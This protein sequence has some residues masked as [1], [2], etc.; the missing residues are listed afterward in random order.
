MRS[1]CRFFLTI[2]IC[3]QAT[4]ARA[5]H[6]G[7]A[8]STWIPGLSDVASMDLVSD[9]PCALASRALDLNDVLGAPDGKFV[10]VGYQGFIGIELSA[11]VVDVPGPDIA[12]WLSCDMEC[13]YASVAVTHNPASGWGQVGTMS[14]GQTY[15]E[16]DIYFDPGNP[17]VR[18]VS[19][20]DA[21]CPDL[22]GIDVDA[23]ANLQVVSAVE[24]TTWGSIKA[25]YR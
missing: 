5:Q 19:V 15:A 7:S 4:F 25:L 24:P 1:F 6:Y 23:V 10:S 22:G 16:F 8:V 20:W 9:S 2:I 14:P 11:D 18:Y 13:R 21:S 12:V 3:S 17:P